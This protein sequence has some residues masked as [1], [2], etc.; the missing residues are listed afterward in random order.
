M[1]WH[2][3]ACA[4]LKHAG[5]E[6]LPSILTLPSSLV[7]AQNDGQRA[8]VSRWQGAGGL[9][10]AQV[11]A[12]TAHLREGVSDDTD[13]QVDEDNSEEHVENVEENGQE[14]RRRGTERLPVA[15]KALIRRR[16]SH[17]HTHTN[18]QTPCIATHWH[19]PRR[20]RRTM[21]NKEEND[22]DKDE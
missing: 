10:G 22:A 20:N 16:T 9:H 17:I 6:V 19:V 8:Y 14:A 1:R 15:C 3:G 12:W 7:I 18:S 2:A 5:D 21:S 11:G 13:E 4:H